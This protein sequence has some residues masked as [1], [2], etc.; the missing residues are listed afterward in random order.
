LDINVSLSDSL[1]LAMGSGNA[2]IVRGNARN[3]YVYAIGQNKLDALA[4]TQ[5]KAGAVVAFTNTDFFIAVDSIFSVDQVGKGTVYYRGNPTIV[6]RT[7]N[8]KI[9]KLD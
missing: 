8:A 5:V 6:T 7:P 3:F 1:T 4:L 9:V 2:N